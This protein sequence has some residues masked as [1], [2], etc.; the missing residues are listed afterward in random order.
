MHQSWNRGYLVYP[1]DARSTHSTLLLDSN[2]DSL[3][4]TLESGPHTR[5]MFVSVEHPLLNQ[6]EPT[7]VPSATEYQVSLPQGPLYGK[8]KV[9]TVGVYFSTHYTVHILRL[10]ETMNVTLSSWNRFPSEQQKNEHGDTSFEEERRV[11][12]LQQNSLWYVPDLDMGHNASLQVR[13]HPVI[14]APLSLHR[15]L[16]EVPQVTDTACECGDIKD[17]FGDDCALQK[18]VEQARSSYC[19]YLLAT[20]PEIEL[21]KGKASVA[22]VGCDIVSWLVNT[23]VSGKFVGLSSAGLRHA[24]IDDVGLLP[25]AHVKTQ[26]VH[27]IDSRFSIDLPPESLMQEATQLLISPTPDATDVEVQTIPLRVVSHAPPISLIF[28]ATPAAFLLPAFDSQD[29]RSEYRLCGGANA[30]ID[31]L[32]ALVLD[33]RFRVVNSSIYSSADCNGP[34][35]DLAVIYSPAECLRE[36]MNLRDLTSLVSTCADE[37]GVWHFIVGMNKPAAVTKLLEAKASPDSTSRGETP[38][39]IAAAEGREAIVRLLLEKQAKVNLNNTDGET[40]LSK[41]RSVPCD[42]TPLVSVL[43]AA[44]C[45]MDSYVLE[46]ALQQARLDVVKTVLEEA[47][48]ALFGDEVKEAFA[49]AIFESPVSFIEEVTPLLA[50]K[51]MPMDSVVYDEPMIAGAVQRCSVEL[52]DFFLAMNATLSRALLKNTDECKDTTVRSKI[53]SLLQ[54]KAQTQRL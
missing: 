9:W 19:I 13:I 17:G 11:Q 15:N 48:P 42:P 25:F 35:Y 44:E 8:I 16:P 50:H 22:G 7:L 2:A 3:T 45:Y 27:G 4:V 20:K 12:Y 53:N 18:P 21:H 6:S 29:L 31:R 28:N 43:T 1:A 52:V 41:E 49:N 24:R 30:A 37:S 26:Q 54:P 33:S 14:F 46:I 5:D 40:A 10:D 39:R 38:L 32:S 23:T 47:S 34:K 51:G 36:A